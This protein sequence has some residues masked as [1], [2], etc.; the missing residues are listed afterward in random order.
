MRAC[1]ESRVEC[2]LGQTKLYKWLEGVL[3]VIWLILLGYSVDVT[4]DF[5]GHDKWYQNQS[6]SV[7]WLMGTIVQRVT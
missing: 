5:L 7:I 3:F 4:S 1:A 6:S 2:L